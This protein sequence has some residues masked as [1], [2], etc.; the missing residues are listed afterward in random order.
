MTFLWL[1][2]QI[3][4][5]PRVL[6]SRS[7]QL[8]PSGWLA[9]SRIPGTYPR[10]R[11]AAMLFLIGHASVYTMS[12]L[13]ST[14]A[15]QGGLT[16]GG[17]IGI[18]TRRRCTVPQALFGKGE[19]RQHEKRPALGSKGSL[20]LYL[21]SAS[22]MQWDRWSKSQ[23]YYGVSAHLYARTDPFCCLSGALKTT[24]IPTGHAS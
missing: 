14:Q 5:L 8:P 3:R 13:S 19:S 16:D 11:L 21:D 10:A 22:V 6:S 18:R 17:R 7:F 20:R 9:S 12:V 23:L 15:A 4:G 2:W 24:K 1:Y